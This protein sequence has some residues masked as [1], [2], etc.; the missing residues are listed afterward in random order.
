VHPRGSTVSSILAQSAGTQRQITAVVRGNISR[1]RAARRRG[2]RLAAM[3]EGSLDYTA[4]AAKA[5][6]ECMISHNNCSDVAYRLLL[7]YL[8]RPSAA[9]LASDPRWR[10]ELDQERKI[11]GNGAASAEEAA[12]AASEVKRADYRQALRVFE[13]WE[14]VDPELISLGVKK[15]ATLFMAS[16]KHAVGGSGD[17]SAL[18]WGELR[19]AE[20]LLSK[21]GPSRHDVLDF[22]LQDEKGARTCGLW[23]VLSTMAIRIA[24]IACA[25]SNNAPALPRAAYPGTL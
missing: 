25:R 22:T 5:Y 21:L 4:E 10:R 9:E 11:A 15:S 24:R 2:D 23:A 19:I 1:A 16:L 6:S 8:D 7:L 14:L 12:A 20:T 17:V 18:R 3:T 13:K